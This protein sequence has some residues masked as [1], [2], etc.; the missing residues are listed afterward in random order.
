MFGL[1]YKKFDSMTYVIHYVNGEVKKEGR[2]LSFFYFGPNSTI[3]AIPLG[4]NDISFIFNETTVDFQ[5]VCIQGQV[6]YKITDPKKIS[7]L[8]DFNLNHKG[9][10]NADDL[11]KLK[12]RL[13]N[14]AHTS[15]SEFVQSLPLKEVLKSAKKIEQKIMEGLKNSAV[16][17]QLGVEPLSVNILGLKP[18]P[19]MARALEAATRES[20][21]QE[22]DQAI[23]ERRNFAVEQER[24]I[25][26]SE[27]NTEIAVVEKRKQITEKQME[28]EILEAE[29]DRKLREMKIEADISVED[30]KKKLLDMQVENERKEAD[31]RKY[32]LES[33]LTPYKEM[34]WK[35]IMAIG[36]NGNDPKLNI[37]LAFRELAENAS[38]I[39]SLNITPD[40]LESLTSPNVNKKS[41]N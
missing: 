15:T 10:N 26:E 40:L 37:A 17:E 19:E 6:T 35:T 13:I 2:G 31:S 14:E 11:E 12:Q 34:D 18:S 25:K 9:G 5:I 3:A 28:K 36:N 39:G 23:Y 8:L 22:A 27:L 41:R 38:K 21:Q 16:V 24:K 29:N 32:L 30:H 20:L 1:N 4:S 7:E 33:S